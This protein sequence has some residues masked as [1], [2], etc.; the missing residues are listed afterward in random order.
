M[1]KKIELSISK[2]IILIVVI[3]IFSGAISYVTAGTVI[4]SEKVSYKDNSGLGVTNV[5]AAIDGTCSNIDNR[6]TTIE[7]SKLNSEWKLLNLPTPAISTDS[8]GSVTL[9]YN[10]NLSEYTEVMPY[11]YVKNFHPASFE[12]YGVPPSSINQ[13]QSW[14][15][16][17][18]SSYNYFWEGV[19]TIRR[20]SIILNT[21]ANSSNVASNYYEIVALYA[22]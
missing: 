20:S 9:T 12:I 3:G 17:R 11:I 8:S 5:Q 19:L 22:R 21:S 1:N 4:D 6:L 16:N 18:S 14:L 13:M 10:I 2:I 15:Y 7:S